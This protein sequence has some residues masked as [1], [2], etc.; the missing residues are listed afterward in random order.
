MKKL[1]YFAV[2]I[3]LAACYY[4]RYE[5]PVYEEAYGY[6]KY[7]KERIPHQRYKDSIEY[8]WCEKKMRGCEVLYNRCLV[9]D[10]NKPMNLLRRFCE[11]KFKTCT[12]EVKLNC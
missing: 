2:M 10:L 3:C 9:R 4:G 6:N 1:I 12:Y 8:R 5:H 11:D 7:Y